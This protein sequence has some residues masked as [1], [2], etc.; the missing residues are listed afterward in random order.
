VNVKLIDSKTTEKAVYN[1]SIL[2]IEILVASRFS[3]VY[4][5][6]FKRRKLLPTAT[7]KK[8]LK[9]WLFMSTFQGDFLVYNC[10]KQISFYYLSAFIDLITYGCCAIKMRIWLCFCF[11]IYFERTRYTKLVRLY[12][13]TYLIPAC[14]L[15]PNF[16]LLHLIKTNFT[17]LLK[18]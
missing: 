9:I 1:F 17:T 14:C 6:I 4:R 11:K 5:Y 13:K 16:P 15:F 18:R 10:R 8:S 12:E 7:K 3:E 2:I